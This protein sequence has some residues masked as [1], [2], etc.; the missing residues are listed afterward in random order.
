[1]IA[2]RDGKREREL[3]R[4]HKDPLARAMG[5]GGGSLNF[6]KGRR[7]KRET[8]TSF[9]TGRRQMVIEE[10]RGIQGKGFAR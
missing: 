1:L 8:E 4:D 2:L 7:R 9:E 5:G 10:G 3:K 6:K